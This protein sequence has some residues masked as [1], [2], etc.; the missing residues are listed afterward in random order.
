METEAFYL[1]VIAALG[2][3]A[4]I[5]ICEG[6]HNESWWG[7]GYVKHRIEDVPPTATALTMEYLR[8][9]T[10]NVL[11]SITFIVPISIFASIFTHD[12]SAVLV[13][14]GYCIIIGAFLVLIKYRVKHRYFGSTAVEAAELIKFITTRTSE[15]N[16]PRSR[17]ISNP[18]LD[19]VS[20]EKAE[21]NA[22]QQGI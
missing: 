5:S 2:F 9:Q 8:Y 10:K 17:R 13:G 6:W 16:P 22:T 3:G 1:I 19:Q 4:T 7:Y 15:G 20:V 12:M 11:R 14:L 18:V 21:A